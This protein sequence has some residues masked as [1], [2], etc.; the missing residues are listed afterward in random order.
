VR[1]AKV[2]QNENS[3]LFALAEIHGLEARR[4]ADARAREAADR[5][6]QR[7]TQEEQAALAQLRAAEL[8]AAQAD[9]AARAA[10]AMAARD[11]DARARIA[12]AETIARAEQQLR[13]QQEALR[14]QTQLRIAERQARP[15]WPWLAAPLLMLAI[16]G[17]GTLAWRGR[18]EA[19]ARADELATGRSEHEQRIAALA[20]RV[21]ALQSEQARLQIERDGVEARLDAASSEQE[22]DQ[23]RAELERLRAQIAASETPSK[24]HVAAPRTTKT[25]RPRAST[26]SDGREADAASDAGRPNAERIE[27]G[28]DG[29][30]PL[31]GVVHD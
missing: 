23:L 9:A 20:D 7:R 25:P 28:D 15:R 26:P 19:D 16:V 4:I 13:V 29:D 18:A 24:P 31:G 14:L 21:A 2:S 6:T 30:D 12:A 10:A 8:A 17:G 3:A 22:R 27:V 5:E 1:V 11:H